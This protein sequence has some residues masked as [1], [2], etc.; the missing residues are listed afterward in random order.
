MYYFLDAV[1][2][3]VKAPLSLLRLPSVEEIKRLS[4][5]DFSLIEY[6]RPQFSSWPKIKDFTVT[7]GANKIDEYLCSFNT[8]EEWSYIIYYLGVTDDDCSS[9]Y[10]YEVFRLIYTRSDFTNFCY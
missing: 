6:G 2:E 10:K 4:Q 1:N 3:S 8:N 9:F 7:L 5:S